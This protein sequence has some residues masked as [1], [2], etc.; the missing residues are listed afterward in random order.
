MPENHLS[1]SVVHALQIASQLPLAARAVKVVSLRAQRTHKKT[2]GIYSASA[3]QGTHTVLPSMVR[4]ISAAL[5]PQVSQGSAWAVS[6]AG[7]GVAWA[8]LRAC[9]RA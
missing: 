3:S 6:T 7:A 2:A 1:E 4:A 5:F 8:S 9:T